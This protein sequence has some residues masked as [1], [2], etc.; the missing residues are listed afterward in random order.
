V[1]T[2]LKILVVDDEFFF[3]RVLKDA[4]KDQY[5]IIEGKNGDEAIS[6]A[7]ALKPNL[8]IMDV[9]M[10][11]KDGIDACR[12]L[13]ENAET[14]KIPV[15]LFTSL[16]KKEDIARGLKVGAD[17]Y[18]TKPMCLPEILARVGAHLR[19]K[20]YYVDL[21]QNDLILL[22]ELAEN[23][24]AIRNPMTILHLIVDKMAGMIGNARCSIVSIN[25]EGVPFVKASSDLALHEDIKLELC[26]YPEIKKA[27]NSKQPVIINDIKNDPLMDSVRTQIKGLNFNSIVVIPVIKKESVIGTFLLRMAT[28]LSDGVTKRIHKLCQLVANLSANALETAILFE[29]TQTAQEF[30][31]EMAIRDGLT[32]L[33]NHQ[34]FYSCL[35]KEF[36][37][38]SRYDTPLSLVFFDIDNFKRINDNYGH[39]HGDM[40]LG[41]IGQLT[42]SIARQSDIPARYG[43]EEFAVILPNTT[44]EGALEMANRLGSMIREHQFECLDGEQ[45]TISSGTSTFT[46]NN[47]K[48]CEQLVQL[49][50]K[51]MYNAKLLGKDRTSQEGMLSSCA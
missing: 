10:P 45:V 51:A 9:E 8:I 22:L 39:T 2:G 5:D 13:K 31:E 4:L 38:A 18:I 36:S 33:Y 25:N 26:R 11:V 42:N 6:L 27:L 23:I 7:R 21:E 12:V 1:Q 34:H 47:V 50:D 40:V 30:F 19:P 37:R 3:R 43:G 46:E 49:A 17:D 28:P 15:I 48:S 24:S 29:R 32:K 41:T 35:E 14:R 20:D 44:S 16:T